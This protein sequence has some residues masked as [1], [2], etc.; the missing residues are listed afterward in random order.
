[1]AALGIW[2]ALELAFGGGWLRPAVRD[3]L[4]GLRRIPRRTAIAAGAAAAVFAALLAPE[5]IRA[6]DFFDQVSFSPNAAGGISASDKGNL[7]QALSPYE[8]LG[9]WPNEDFRTYFESARTAYRAG[10]AGAVGILGLALGTLWWLRRRDFV[11]P[12]AALGAALIFLYLKAGDESPYVE[13]K[14]LAVLAPVAMALAVGGLLAARAD[15]GVGR[16]TLAL[17]A[18]FVV[19]AGASSFLALRGS[20]VGP[21][22]H[23][24]ELASL[25][26]LVAGRT[27][28]ALPTDFFAN[29]RLH[30]AHVSGSVIPQPVKI[31]LRPEKGAGTGR[32]LDFDWVTP[33]TLDRFEFV[34]TAR[35]RYASEPPAN[36][37]RVR[38]TRSYELWRR[39]GPTP[40]RR[41]LSRERFDPGAILD[42]RTEE[43]RRLR[44]QAGWARIMPAPALAIGPPGRRLPRGIRQSLKPGESVGRRLRLPEGRYELSLI[45]NA[46]RAPRLTTVGLQTSLTAQLDPAGPFWHAAEIDWPGGTLLLRVD[47][48]KMRLGAS[49]QVTDVGELA[50]VRL[51]DPRRLVPLRAACGRYVD[52]YVL[53]RDRPPVPRA[54]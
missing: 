46:P 43:G 34:V 19:L 44:T 23:P 3:A 50:A 13:A 9:I 39:S 5:A 28:L 41:V 20:Y 21:P 26:P 17:A 6:L 10:L 7:A 54:I 33:Q 25:R 27:V 8:A 24:D 31:E 52:W 4:G 42:C 30:G 11:V 48:A 16:A 29:T 36:F 38:T 32:P 53:G 49:N 18:L 35:G 40:E 45:Y 1:V 22:E 2:V 14:A 15:D 51:D 12:A 47:A 37:R